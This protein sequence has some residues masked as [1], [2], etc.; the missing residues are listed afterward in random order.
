M[1]RAHPGSHEKDRIMANTVDGSVTIG[2]QQSGAW[3]M[4]LPLAIRSHLKDLFTAVNMVAGIIAVHLVLDD[5]P[6]AA[7]FAVIIGFIFGDLLDGQV[8]RLTRTSNRFGAEFDSIVDHFVHV[9]VPGL[10]VYTIY[11]DAGHDQLGIAA[12]GILVGMA[13]LRHARLAA[14]RFDY[15]LCWCGLPRTISGFAAMAMP[16]SET[17]QR[18]INGDLWLGFGLITALSIMNVMPIPYM[19]HRGQRAMQPWAK[20]LVM[21]FL[22]T[23]IVTFFVNRDYTFDVFCLWILGYSLTGWVPVH[24]DERR[25]FWTEYRRWSASLSE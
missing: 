9:V 18:H 16:L 13:T 10:I 11:D 24:P 15:P 3:V 1:T 14:E 20:W 2:A 23:T 19:T 22:G 12:F 4:R 5:K 7:G 21:L 17:F 6:R 25:A 8:A